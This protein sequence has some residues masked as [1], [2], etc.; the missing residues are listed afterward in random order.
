M[1][2]VQNNQSLIYYF[3]G[4]T[5]TYILL[6]K[7]SN[8]RFIRLSQKDF[9]KETLSTFLQMCAN[10]DALN[11]N[12]KSFI[13]SSNSIYKAIFRQLNLPK[14]RVIICADNIVIPFE[15]LCKDAEGKNF[16]LNDYS[17][18]YVYSARFL[19]KQ[20]NSAVA[21]GDFIGFA[22]VFF[23]S[24]LR[25]VDLKSAAEALDAAAAY[26]KNHKLFTYKNATRNNFFNYTSSYSLVTIFSHAQGDTTGSEPMLFMHDSLIYLS[27]L[28]RLNNPATKLV[29]LSA[30]ETN[31]GKA[32]IGEGIYSLARGFAAAG[33]PSVA[34]TL[35]KA[36]EQ[37]IY[38]VSEK[39]NDYLSEGMNKDEALQKAKL[40]FI[41][42]NPEKLLPYYWAN[43]ILIGNTDAISFS[44]I[45]NNYWW[46]II[47]CCLFIAI[48]V[49]IRKRLFTHGKIK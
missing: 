48:A 5:A 15:A 31:V 29:L 45:N 36:D 39:F 33:I 38:A 13:Q 40:Y 37:S 20:F 27:E 24:S 22:P 30:C 43:M 32:A 12:Y 25:V 2:L 44:K 34:A 41:N 9:N 19:M 17:F 16:L 7:P 3:L 49:I 26:Y 23:D 6:I 46:W 8:T 18:S 10:K 21:K 47:G 4:D 35:W 1:T 42:S 11:N 14:G 28:Q